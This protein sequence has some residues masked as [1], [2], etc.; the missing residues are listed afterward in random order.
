M[1]YNV[2]NKC[3]KSYC[4]RAI[5]VQVVVE[6]VTAWFWDTMYGEWNFLSIE[7]HGPEVE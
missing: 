6:N 3:T 7:P 2:S 5:L 1:S 4:N